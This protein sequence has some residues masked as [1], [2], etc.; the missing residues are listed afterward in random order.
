MK[1][2]MACRVILL[3]CL[4]LPGGRVAAATGVTAVTGT[5]PLASYEVCTPH[6]G[7][8][9]ALVSWKTNGAATSQVFYDTVSRNSVAEY[10]FFTDERQALVEKHKVTLKKLSPSTVYYYRVRSAAE[11]A[12][13]VS[14]EYT[15]TTLTSPGGWKG[16]LINLFAEFTSPLYFWWTW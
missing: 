1:W 4:M 7:F 11:G 14:E 9:T 13:F 5:V 8:F 2:R 3:A 16:W 15:F 6:V 12:E 10:A